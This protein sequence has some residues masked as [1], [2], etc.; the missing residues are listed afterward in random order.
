MSWKKKKE[1]KQTKQML[2]N[3]EDIKSGQFISF[4]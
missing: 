1:K 2:T 4:E 3:K